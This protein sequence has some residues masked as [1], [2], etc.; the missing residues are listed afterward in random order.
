VVAVAA[1]AP[2]AARVRAACS[3]WLIL[4]I[5][6]CASTPPAATSPAAAEAALDEFDRRYLQAINDGDIET[7]AALTTDDHMMISSGRPP[8]AGKQALVDAMTR[9]FAAFDIDETWAVEET[10]VSDGLAY[11][12]GTF[13]VLAAPKAGGAASRTTGSFVRI[14]RRLADGGW[15]LVRDVLASD[16]A[17]E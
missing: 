3:A 11:R 8:M 5:A 6:G 4:L 10:M 2:V 16:A 17:R 9:A 1:A 7:L 14:Y 12:R 15:Y 13:V